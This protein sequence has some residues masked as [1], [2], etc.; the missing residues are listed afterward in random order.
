MKQL[1][2]HTLTDALKSLRGN[3]PRVA[4]RLKLNN[5]ILDNRWTNILDGKLLP[6]YLPDLPLIA[7]ICGGGSSGKST[8]FNS[9]VGEHLSPVG[10]HTGIN[11]RVLVSAHENIFRNEKTLS[12]LFEPFG[13]IPRPLK[14]M[15]ELTVPGPPLYLIHNSALRNLV[16]ID[17]PEIDTGF[18]GVYTNRDIAK[19][20]MEMSDILIYIFTAT[21]HNNQANTNF[22]AEM[23]TDLSLKKCFLVYRVSNGFAEQEIRK[24]TM[25][26]ARN[27]YGSEADRYVLG[28]YRTSEDNAVAAG[29]RFMALKPVHEKY[30]PLME[31]LNS[32]EPQ[33]LRPELLSLTLK[34]VLDKAEEVFAHVEHSV[35]ELRLY[36][37]TLQAANRRCVYEALRHFSRDLVVKRFA[38]IWL[39]INLLLVRDRH[40]TDGAFHFLNK[41][42]LDT[43][44]RIKDW[45]Y[46]KKKDNLD[47][48][49]KTKVQEALITAINNMYCLT[50]DSEFSVPVYNKDPIVRQ[51]V[52]TVKRIKLY[53]DILF[54]DIK[55]DR[56]PH[57][58][59]SNENKS[60]RLFVSAHPAVSREQRKLQDKNWTSSIQLILSHT[61]SFLTLSQDMERELHDLAV[62]FRNKMRFRTKVR[63]TFSALINVLSATATPEIKLDDLYQLESRLSLIANAW[64]HY[65][66]ITVQELFEQEITGGIIRVAEDVIDD[67]DTLLRE[68]ESAIETCRKVLI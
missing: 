33:K 12:S 7:A 49:F 55:N 13:Y 62:S 66:K 23:L 15:R 47:V 19:Q 52:E 37:D 42:F 41:L 3:I 68:I 43:A 56:I 58:E 38:E 16:L 29:E 5:S 31:S 39:S 50:L 60:L 32:I 59:S 45:F 65:T 22:I 61:N 6:R 8:L 21:N 25:T 28:I 14:D 4:D 46:A 64:L 48:N 30:P 63:Q 44:M 51:I 9:L 36:R 27:L 54:K 35:D 26:V 18:N 17:T 40:K 1:Y 57:I 53:K 20:A 2:D 24:Q 11:R 67:S 10:G 34:G